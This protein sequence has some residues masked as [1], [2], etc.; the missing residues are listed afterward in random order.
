V[1]RYE[2]SSSASEE[3]VGRSFDE[4]LLLLLPE[5]SVDVVYSSSETL[6]ASASISLPLMFSPPP[7][8]P[9]PAPLLILFEGA[10]LGILDAEITVRTWCGEGR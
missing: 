10:E 5:S 3:G 2:S 6:S 4:E 9:P 8:P 1:S 7:P